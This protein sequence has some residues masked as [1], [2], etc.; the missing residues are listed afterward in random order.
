MTKPTTTPTEIDLLRDELA[1]HGK[2]CDCAHKLMCE[3]REVWLLSQIEPT[4]YTSPRK[5][6]PNQIQRIEEELNAAHIPKEVW[7]GTDST[8]D[9]VTWLITRNKL[10]QQNSR[11]RHTALQNC[12]EVIEA[13]LISTD[14]PEWREAAEYALQLAGRRQ[15]KRM[16]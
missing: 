11:S 14:S 10:N 12:A 3:D 7:I 6:V 16:I 8:A 13:A 9:R 1:T 2:T 15:S 5:S 4:K